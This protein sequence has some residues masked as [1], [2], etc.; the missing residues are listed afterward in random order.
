M[1]GGLAPVLMTA[2]ADQLRASTSLTNK[3]RQKYPSLTTAALRT[4]ATGFSVLPPGKL[5]QELKVAFLSTED[6]KQN[7]IHFLIANGFL[8][9]G[10]TEFCGSDG[11]NCSPV[12]PLDLNESTLLVLGKIAAA[13]PDAITEAW[14]ASE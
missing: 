11:I 2:V 9:D 8:H 7:I 1:L 14:A 10:S 12:F 13:F 6:S 3:Y 4:L 5:Q